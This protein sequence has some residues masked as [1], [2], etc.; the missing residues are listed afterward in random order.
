[1]S[2]PEKPHLNLVIMGHVDHGKSTTTGHMLYLAGVVDERTVKQ[3]EEE[4]R[5]IGKETFKFAWILDNLKEERERGLT[6]DLRFLKFE[7]KKYYFTIID[8]PGHRDFVKNMITGA[9]QADGAILFVSAKRGEFEAGIGAGGQTR[10]H[11]FLAFT[12]GVN[13]LVVAVNKMDDPSVNWSQERYNEIKNEVSRMLRMVGYKVE[14]IPFV[15]VSGWTGDNLV[16]PSDKMPW[17]KGPTLLEALDTFELPPK[18][19]DKPLRIPIQDVYS[20]T[21]VGTVPVGRVETGVLK[22]GDMVIF[23]P[24]NKQGE[25]KSIEMHH[26][27][28]PRAEPGDNI[29]F[30]V[31]GVAKTDIRRGDVCGHV[32]NPPTVAREFIGQIIVI[33]HPTAIAAGY[34]PVLHYHTG[35]MACRFTE[36]I[37]KIDPRSGQVVEEKPSFLKTGDAALVRMEPLRPISIETYA[38]FPELGRFAV[39]DMGTTIAAGI[40]KEIT[41]K[42]L[43]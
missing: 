24:A 42:G 32:S 17:Y 39:R 40:V 1:M 38:E 12:L 37:R 19:L 43:Q 4:A 11:A 13:Q 33:Y 27:R 7:T 6:I 21:G 16:K 20:I 25:V 31:R 14:K 18:P 3:Y 26:T 22:E 5:K 28:I 34:T 36:L 9:S 23:M 41:K 8:A 10:E 35:Q 30:N 2:R 15:P 29:G